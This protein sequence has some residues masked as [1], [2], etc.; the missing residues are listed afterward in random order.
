MKS[1]YVI[2]FQVELMEIM[3]NMHKAL[4]TCSTKSQTEKFRVGALNK[5]HKKLCQGSNIFSVKLLGTL[6]SSEMYLN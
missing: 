6:Q 4:S 3:E 1:L 2:R 5:K